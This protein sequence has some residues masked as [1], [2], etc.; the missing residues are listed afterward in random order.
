[1]SAETLRGIEDAIQAHIADEGDGNV[2]AGWVA[3]VYSE[4]MFDGTRSFYQSLVPST[5]AY[6]ATTGLVQM[7]H[8]EYEYPP[9]GIEEDDNDQG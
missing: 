3:Y 5:Q 8:A 2:A 9:L 7:L 6:H 1:V 4:S